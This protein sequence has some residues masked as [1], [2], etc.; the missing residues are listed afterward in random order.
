MVLCNLHPAVIVEAST[1]ILEFSG[2]VSN[3][4]NKEAIFTQM[5]SRACLLL[6]QV[7][8]NCSVIC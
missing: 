5:V 4:Q 8:L 7:A 1:E 3:A 6:A 2:M